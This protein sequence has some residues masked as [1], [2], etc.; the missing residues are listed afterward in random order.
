MGE[1]L[2]FLWLSAVG[3]AC[4]VFLLTKCGQRTAHDVPGAANTENLFVRWI[5]IRATGIKVGYL[6]PA[7]ADNG[8]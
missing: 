2:G 4:I 6:R 3:E 8:K 5:S 7:R 1:G